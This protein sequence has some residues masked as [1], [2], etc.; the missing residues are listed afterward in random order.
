[1]SRASRASGFRSPGLPASAKHERTSPPEN[2][3]APHSASHRVPGQVL[4]YQAIFSLDSRQVISCSKDKTI[5]VWDIK[6]ATETGSMKTD[7][8]PVRVVRSADGRLIAVAGSDG[9]EVWSLETRQRRHQIK[10]GFCSAVTIAPDGKTL[11]YGSVQKVDGKFSSGVVLW[12]LESERQA[13]FLSG[14]AKVPLGIVYSDD[15]TLMATCSGD[16][17]ARIWRL[18]DQKLLQTLQGHGTVVADVAMSSDK[19]RVVTAGN[20]KTV[21]VWDTADGR[22]LQLFKG[23]SDIVYS[24]DLHPGGHDFVSGSK[25][26]SV[27]IWKLGD[28]TGVKKFRTDEESAIRQM[29]FLRDGQVV[30]GSSKGTL[31][32][33]DPSTGQQTK[34]LGGVR[35]VT[36][37][38]MS[39]P[40][41]VPRVAACGLGSPSIELLSLA[42]ESRTSV[43]LE[44]RGLR[45]AVSPDAT[46]AAAVDGRGRVSIVDL[47]TGEQAFMDGSH[48]GQVYAVTWHPNGDLFATGSYDTTIRLWDASSG[49][50]LSLLTGHELAVV[51]LAFNSDGSLLA[52]GSASAIEMD[53]RRDPPR[54]GTI[55][56]WDLAAHKP[57]GRV[58]TG[59]SGGVPALAFS[60]D[61]RT[62][63][64]ASHDATVRL[65]DPVTGSQT[66]RFAGDG[67]RFWSVTFSTDGTQ[68][69]AGADNGSI[70]TWSA[71]RP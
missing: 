20:D 25:D 52:S 10:G 41:E 53:Q 1:L 38:L 5:R 32:I 39:V 61:D 9:I 62:L 70:H 12:N 14:H 17:T 22:Q 50:E 42:D 40:S 18:S 68:L 46:Q 45:F 37:S 33:W 23:H 6:T 15:G 54:P 30:T 65:W 21:R 4:T 35:G 36:M 67:G 3:S 31:Q 44:A 13:A 63:V 56:L 60:P 64:S 49:Q 28:Q 8:M 57:M 47:T 29:A 11:A 16:G 59:H 2:R 24:V 66:M 27:R 69:A 19:T 43:E 34:K 55:R 26:G 71:T 51:G 48:R 7:L 58:I